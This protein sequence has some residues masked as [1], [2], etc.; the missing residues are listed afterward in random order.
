M[1]L[2]R[3][4]LGVATMALALS[5]S[6]ASPILFILPIFVDISREFFPVF[7]EYLPGPGKE[8]L[9]HGGGVFIHAESVQE[10]LVAAGLSR[11]GAEKHPGF[12]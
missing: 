1:K 5:A 2:T 12:K 3:R 8:F 6:V 9:V 10:F 4:M 11:E 7:R